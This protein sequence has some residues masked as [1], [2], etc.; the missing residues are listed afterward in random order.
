MRSFPTFSNLTIFAFLLFFSCSQD[1]TMDLEPPQKLEF[2]SFVPTIPIEDQYIVVFH[3]E[4]ISSRLI[5]TD[6][7]SMDLSMRKEVVN[8]LSTY[9]ISE[10]NIQRVYSSVLN[11]FCAKLDKDQL[12]KIKKDPLVKYVE[13][14]RGG[15]LGPLTESIAVKGNTD[16]VNTQ[17]VPWGITRVGGPFTYKGKNSVFVVDTGIQL[18]HPDLNVCVEKAFDAYHPIDPK[19]CFVDEHGHGT[20]VAGTIGALDNFIGVVGVAAGV[21]LVPVKIFFGPFAQYSYSGMIA[22]IDHVGKVGIPGDVAN[23]SFGGFDSSRALDDAVLNAS[24]SKKI[25]MV[26]ASGNSNLP[27]NSFSPARV[28]GNFTITVS[29]IDALDRFA[30]FSH[31]GF[32][33]K[34]AAPGVNVYST[35]IGGRYRYLSGTSMATPHVAGLRV[36]GEIGNDGFAINYPVTPPDPIAYRPKG[37]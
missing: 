16:P 18:D 3:E 33:I 4:K 37:K 7:Q 8:L 34:F 26:I 9:R 10:D 35:N 25:W 22:G 15:A 2:T 12:E 24:E 6:V 20:H 5:Q 36:L 11:G 17:I 13:Q 32:P 29:A 28:S 1:E 30:W 19:L 14:D 23:L 21:D 31:Y 27:A